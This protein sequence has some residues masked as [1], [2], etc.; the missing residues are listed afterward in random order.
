MGVATAK[1]CRRLS[2]GHKVTIFLEETSLEY[3]VIPINIGKA[4]Q[5]APEFKN[6]PQQQ[7][8]SDRRS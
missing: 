2:H 7:D 4:D 8:A 1:R 3:K 5:F 6:Q